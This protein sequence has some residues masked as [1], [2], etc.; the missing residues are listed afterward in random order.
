[1][2]LGVASKEE[3][4]IVWDVQPVR[5]QRLVNCA[6]YIYCRT[7]AL[8][9]VPVKRQTVGQHRSLLNLREVGM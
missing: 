9:L 2:E 4:A 5:G 3:T 7:A 1:M 6:P 8:P